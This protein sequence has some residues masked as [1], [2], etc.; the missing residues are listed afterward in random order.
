MADVV[1]VVVL[2]AVGIVTIGWVGGLFRADTVVEPAAVDYAA[3]AATAQDAADFELAVPADLPD[4]W[5]ATSA[6]WHSGEQRWHL[7]LLTAEDEYVGLEQL[8]AGVSEARN[9]VA[10]GST[11]AG[12]VMIAGRSWMRL[13]DEDTGA[14]TLLRDL[15]SSTLLVSGSAPEPALVG[16]AERV[17]AASKS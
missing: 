9:A 14:V 13:V 12:S 4:G 10:P 17:T 2:F 8:S 7:G 11:Q 3:I 15:R 5:R 6:R 16:F 1:R